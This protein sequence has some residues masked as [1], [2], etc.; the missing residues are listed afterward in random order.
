MKKII[1]T[2]SIIVTLFSCG[3]DD[4]GGEGGGGN[5][6]A[7]LLS[8]PAN[9]T[10][11]LTGTDV[12]STQ[13]K[14]TFNWAAADGTEK[15]FLYVKNL[16]TQSSLQFN[17]AA[18]TS[19]EVTLTKGAPYS[20]YVASRKTSGSTVNSETW[21]FYN[22]GTPVT[23]HAPFPADLISPAMSSTVSGTSV[24][25]EWSGSDIDNDIETYSVY[26]GTA[27]NPSTL[28]STVT[29][30]KIENIAVIANTT[31]YWKVVTTDSAGNQTGSPVF[32]F[33]VN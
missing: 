30:Q 7:A 9:N 15:Y 21:K 24:T 1:F 3:G 11:C 29:Q 10:E 12:S 6:S 22:A 25:L 2:M 27:T 33:K 16:D 4:N 8:A 14:V 32:Q 17:A 18:A 26:F 19:F 5:Q 20:W 13:N 23:T 31:Y 28:L